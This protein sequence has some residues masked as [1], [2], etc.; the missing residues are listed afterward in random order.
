MLIFWTPMVPLLSL[1]IFAAALTNLFLFDAGIWGFGVRLPANLANRQAAMSMS[2]LR[3]ALAAGSF[4]QLCY[5]FGTQMYG[6]FFLLAFH[7]VVLGPWG[8]QLLPLERATRYFWTDVNQAKV[9][10]VEM[11]ETP[12][13]PAEI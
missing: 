5:A 7:V 8:K 2:Y 11:K 1:G 12:S 4:F 6:R 3:F 10:E 9:P 13:D